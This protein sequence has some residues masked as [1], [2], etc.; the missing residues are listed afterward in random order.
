MLRLLITYGRITPIVVLE[1]FTLE[2][3]ARE[4][5]VVGGPRPERPGT[6][7]S[8]VLELRG[9]GCRRGGTRALERVD[10]QVTE[11]ELHLLVVAEAPDAAERA[12]LSPARLRW[13]VLLASGGARPQAT[14]FRTFN[15]FAILATN[16]SSDN[17]RAST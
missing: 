17:A 10:L 11:G 12:G 15:G 1:G 16:F 3:V 6:R 2:D 7:R 4:V 8:T 9:V 13:A 14:N 5:R